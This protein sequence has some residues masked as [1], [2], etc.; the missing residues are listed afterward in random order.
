M[1]DSM[2]ERLKEV[3]RQANKRPDKVKI[4]ELIDAGI[5]DKKGRVLKKMQALPSRR[6][7][8][9]GSP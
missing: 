4:Q 2:I 3:V 8:Q 1:K 7:R 6:K 9:R 5:V